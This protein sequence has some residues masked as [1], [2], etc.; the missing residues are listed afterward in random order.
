MAD[1]PKLEALRLLARLAG[2]TVHDNSRG[3]LW[4]GA[5]E[6]EACKLW[7]LFDPYTNAQ[8]LNDL[9]EQEKVTVRWSEGTKRWDA[10]G[11]EAA[12]WNADDSRTEAAVQCLARIAKERFNDA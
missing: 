2:V 7:K 12:G 3:Q 1:L 5:N 10:Y 9:I 11:P 6:Q 8:Q 4:L